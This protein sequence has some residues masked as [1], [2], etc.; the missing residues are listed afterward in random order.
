MII[1]EYF[2]GAPKLNRF[3]SNKVGIVGGND[4]DIKLHPWQISLQIKKK[5]LCGGSLITKQWVVTAAHCIDDPNEW[6]DFTVVAGTTKWDVSGQRLGIKS[7]IVHEQ[8][9]NVSL[10][11]DIAL[12]ELVSNTTIENAEPVQLPPTEN[13]TLPIGA[14]IS[15]TGWGLTTEGG[16]LSEILQVV[17]LEYLPFEDCARA[18]SILTPM[19]L[20]AGGSPV[21]GK[22]TC[23][24]DSGGPAIY[25]NDI[26]VGIT[27][28]G[29]GCAL[30]NYP[31]VYTNVAK[32]LPWIKKHV[33]V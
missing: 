18:Y 15:A 20:C 5:H 26:L 24:S 27:S 19:M 10:S 29:S 28:F 8:W 2:A 16:N 30:P 21:G 9:D 11:N 32:Y 25:E 7:V 14:N 17:T 33:Q 3:T 1:V 13:F 6:P 23:Q 22:G 4:T 12:L 31:D